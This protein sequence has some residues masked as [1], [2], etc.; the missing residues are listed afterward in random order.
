MN[1]VGKREAM[2]FVSVIESNFNIYS[3]KA[4]LVKFKKLAVKLIRK[5]LFSFGKYFEGIENKYFAN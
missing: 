5:L 1:G 4:F 2:K 3:G